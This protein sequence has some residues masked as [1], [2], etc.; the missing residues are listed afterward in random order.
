M[1]HVGC[2]GVVKLGV[3]LDRES[4]TAEKVVNA[5]KVVNSNDCRQAVAKLQKIYSMAGGVDKAA[6]LVKPLRHASSQCPGM[7]L[8]VSSLPLHLCYKPQ[9]LG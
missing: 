7:A 6:D 5:L 9:T 3:R 2:S 8:R 1:S 4:L